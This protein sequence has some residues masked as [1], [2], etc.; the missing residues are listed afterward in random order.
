MT[1]QILEDIAFDLADMAVRV[2]HLPISH[3]ASPSNTDRDARALDPRPFGR[4]ELS[5]RSSP[6]QPSA[7]ISPNLAQNSPMPP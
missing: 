3:D 7:I 5:E 6:L 4:F 2:D 1:G